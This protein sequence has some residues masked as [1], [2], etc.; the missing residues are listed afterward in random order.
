MLT[1]LTRPTPASCDELLTSGQP[2]K[3]RPPPYKKSYK[4]AEVL[5]NTNELKASINSL[6]FVVDIR[7]NY[8]P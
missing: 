3:R 4:I 1:P 2:I 6:D 5:K 8:L 7:I